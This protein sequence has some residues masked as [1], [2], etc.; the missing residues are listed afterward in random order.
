MISQ[1]IFAIRPQGIHEP[2]ADPEMTS[3]AGNAFKTNKKCILLQVRFK[4]RNAK[5]MVPVKE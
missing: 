3:G 5:N 1:M 2:F 4:L